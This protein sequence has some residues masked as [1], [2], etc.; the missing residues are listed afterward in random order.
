MNRQGYSTMAAH[1][2]RVVKHA[3][4]KGIGSWL[5]NRGRLLLHFSQEYAAIPGLYYLL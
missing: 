5:G 2:G 1:N 4:I 3:G